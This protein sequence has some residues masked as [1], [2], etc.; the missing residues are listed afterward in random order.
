[1][2]KATDLLMQLQDGAA[3]GAAGAAGGVLAAKAYDGREGGLV[4]DTQGGIG[5]APAAAAGGT[6]PSGGSAAP[7]A[8]GAAGGLAAGALGAGLVRPLLISY[9]L[10]AEYLSS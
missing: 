6:G 7:L 5:S 2:H 3:L 4:S 8:A 1:M 10:L 9:V